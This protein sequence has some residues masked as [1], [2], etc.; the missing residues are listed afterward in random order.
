VYK[1]MPTIPASELRKRQAEVMA[2]IKESPVLLTHNGHA[3]G[4]L[5]HPQVWNDI[6]DI[7]EQWLKDNLP[8]VDV[9]D[10]V[11]WE[12]FQRLQTSEVAVDAVG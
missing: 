12:E 10:A 5:V 4:I 9:S 6:L 7:Y 1:A 11:P 3:A 2:R 8:T